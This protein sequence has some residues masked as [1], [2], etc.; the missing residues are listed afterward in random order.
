MSDLIKISGGTVYD[1]ANGI[2][3]EV[4]D[5]WIEGGKIVAAPADP[6]R[7]PAREIDARGL[8]VMP[9][10]VDMHCHIAGPKVN[11]ARKMRPEEKRKAEVLHRTA[12][13]H[14]GTLG[15]VPSTFATGYKYAGMGYTTA[16]DAAIPPLGARHAHEEFEDTP[17]IDKGFYVLMGN[18]HYVM[19]SIQ[20]NEPQ[21]L[22]AFIAWL[23]GAT[24][25]FAPKLVN[26]G[27]V[28]VWKSHQGGN[29]HSIDDP[30]DHFGVTPRQ[31]IGGVAKAAGELGLPHAVHIHCN[32]LGIPGNWQTTLETMKAL[33][34]HRAHITHVQFHSYGGGEGDENTFNSKTVP[35]AEY[36]NAH[37][38][39]T[40]DVGQVMFGET[41]SMT[42]DGPLGYYLSNIF[43]GKW[44]S[45]DTEMEA[46]CG[47]TPIKYRNKSLVHSLQWA[48]GLEWYLLV[49]DP[50]RVV[51]STDH[52]N[53]GSF[54]AYPQII[55]LL[56]DRTYRRDV[57]KKCPPQVVERSTL[58]ELDREYTL[59]EI[60]I[61]TRAGPARILGLANKGHLGAGADADI[62]I[63]TPHE[64]K[65]IM[66]QTPRTVIKSGRIM[67]E[68]GEMR[69]PFIGKTLHVA[70]AYDREIE[71]DIQEWFEQYYSIRWRNYPVD[72]SYLHESELVPTVG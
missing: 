24:K 18:N 23:L 22:K 3:G 1:P 63:Y 6:A 41:T 43:K 60:A 30:V 46:G 55:R 40:I 37:K 10:G 67:I 20:Q 50:W 34:G 2:D 11:V 65:E 19:R 49:D 5:I 16:F 66:F 52:P 35:L 25:G 53:G 59:G 54:L 8:V 47:I 39:V 21:K 27:G 61:I 28:E 17:C 14:S 9:G 36:V 12:N 58:A 70:P 68:D 48:I 33:D 7:R 4:R 44:F 56:M 31:I 26:P 13:T 71:S 45:A 32:N 72:D 38:N 57:L 64:N 15:S 69:D 42:G 29:V 51:M 62:T